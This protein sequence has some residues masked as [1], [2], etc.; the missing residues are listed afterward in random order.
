MD[1]AKKNPVNR[2]ES[3]NK[4]SKIHRKRHF[5]YS[6]TIMDRDTR[7]NIAFISPMKSERELTIM[8]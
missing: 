8:L 4:V 5:T 7:T 1:N 6:F 2:K 3:K